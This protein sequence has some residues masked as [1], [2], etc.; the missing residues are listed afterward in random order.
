M[1]ATNLVSVTAP[2]TSPANITKWKIITLSAKTGTFTGSFILTDVV[3]A[4]T[5]ANP[6]ATRSVPRT[7]PFSGVLRQA[8]SS[9]GDGVIGDGYYL[10]PA[11]PGAA[12]NEKVSGEVLFQTPSP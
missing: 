1:S 8:P 6:A 11:L 2:V 12:S 3:P 5:V 7:V 9:S 4:P 10:L